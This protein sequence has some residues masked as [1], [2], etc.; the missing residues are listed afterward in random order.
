[1]DRY[2]REAASYGSPGVTRSMPS[3]R[4]AF[5]SAKTGRRRSNSFHGKPSSVVHTASDEWFHRGSEDWLRTAVTLRTHAGGATELARAESPV[6]RE[7][8]A[9]EVKVAQQQRQLRRTASKTASRDFKNE[10][11]CAACAKTVYFMERLEANDGLYHKACFKCCECQ[12][13][14]T[15]ATFRSLDDRIYCK[16]HYPD[17]EA[18][19]DALVQPSSPVLAV[20]PSLRS[21]QAPLS[22]PVTKGPSRVGRTHSAPQSPLGGVPEMSRITGKAATYQQSLVAAAS[23]VPKTNSPNAHKSSK[24]KKGV[25]LKEAPTNYDRRATLWDRDGRHKQQT[26]VSSPSKDRLRSTVHRHHS[27]PAMTMQQVT[28]RQY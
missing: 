19:A 17:S 12:A 10:S 22:Q 20:N 18:V 16:H 23:K 2:C 8:H 24:K 1:M 6:A 28:M 4:K 13:T 5:G 25:P 15:T 3:K 21:E 26:K 27:S 14:L 11:L 9:V 7:Q